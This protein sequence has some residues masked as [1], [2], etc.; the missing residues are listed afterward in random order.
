M[1]KN[2]GGFEAGVTKFVLDVPDKTGSNL[3][4]LP[5]TPSTRN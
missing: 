4:L 1:M 3:Q 5:V 2:N